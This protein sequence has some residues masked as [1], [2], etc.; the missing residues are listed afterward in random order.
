MFNNEQTRVRS[1]ADIQATERS[2]RYE[3]RQLRRDTPCPLPSAIETTESMADSQLRIIL[4]SI[5]T[6]LGNTEQNVHDWLDVISL[7]FDIIGYDPVQRRRYLPQYLGDDA[8]KW[9]IAN[10]EQLPLWDDYIQALATA[11]P[12]ITAISRDLQLQQ[13]KD[14]KQ[15]PRELFHEYYVSILQLC[16]QYDPL[17]SEAHIIDWLKSGM[18]LNLLEKIQGDDFITSSSLLIRAQ[19]LEL[20]ATVLDA[21]RAQES[22]REAQPY[23]TRFSRSTRQPPHSTYTM[24]LP[25]MSS[26]QQ[27]SSHTYRTP[28]PRIYSSGGEQ[29]PQ[30]NIHCYTCGRPGHIARNCT[31]YP[32]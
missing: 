13:L 26:H 16:R 2:T 28:F 12:R 19:R 27:S 5:P 11:F 7:K 10:R 25:L 29:K 1:R 18:S 23:P 15:G 20:D 14:R 31:I 17:M 32:N 9:H 21:R 3:N 4:E 8:L 24:A 30:V 6:F 22:A